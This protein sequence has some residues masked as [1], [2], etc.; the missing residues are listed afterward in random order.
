MTFAPF[1]QEGEGPGGKFRPR[2]LRTSPKLALRWA[3]FRGSVNSVGWRFGVLRERGERMRVNVTREVTALEAMKV[4]ELRARYA[5]VFGEE[6]RVGNKKTPS[7][8]SPS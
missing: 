3:L 4:A 8:R 7:Y 5:E 2:N 1:S 6:T